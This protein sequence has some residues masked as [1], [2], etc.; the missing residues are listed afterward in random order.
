MKRGASRQ[1]G[2]D[3]DPDAIL[4]SDDEEAQA[5]APQQSSTPRT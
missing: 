1:L 3:D 5:P 2:K 4:G